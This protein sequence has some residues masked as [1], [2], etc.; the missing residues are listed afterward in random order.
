MD[1]AALP[2]NFGRCRV[3]SIK[4]LDG[5]ALL[6]LVSTM[7]RWL[8]FFVRSGVNVF[9]DDAALFEFGRCRGLPFSTIFDRMLL[10]AL[11]LTRFS[12]LRSFVT[13]L[14]MVPGKFANEIL[15]G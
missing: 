6:F 2:L 15:T 1:D 7:R 9:L 10:E 8:T 3:L 5:P 13:I 4:R 11:E 14:L 12:F